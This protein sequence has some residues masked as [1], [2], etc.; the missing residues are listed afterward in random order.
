MPIRPPLPKNQ[1]DIYKGSFFQSSFYD[2]VFVYELKPNVMVTIDMYKE[3]HESLRIIYNS[4]GGQF[5]IMI[6]ITGFLGMDQESRRIAKLHREEK[7]VYISACV[8][9]SG[10]LNG[11]MRLIF[12]VVG[13]KSLPKNFFTKERKAL[14]WL[15]EKRKELNMNTLTEKEVRNGLFLDH[16]SSDF[17]R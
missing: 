4:L 11:M 17:S 7:L 2:G 9:P 14:K 3:F 5:P 12:T 16:E 13:S 1:I 6:K 8:T 15:E 10:L